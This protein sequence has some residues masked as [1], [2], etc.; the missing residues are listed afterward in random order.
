MMRSLRAVA[1]VLA[2]LAF[3]VSAAAQPVPQILEITL[4]TTVQPGQEF[5]FTVRATNRGE[6]AA[7]GSISVSFPD[8]D[9]V[10]V[11]DSS[12]LTSPGLIRQ[13]LHDRPAFIQFRTEPERALCVSAGGN[14][15]GGAVAARRRAFPDPSGC[16]T[17]QPCKLP[18]AGACHASDDRRLFH[19]PVLGTARPTGV[20]GANGRS[21]G[22]SASSAE[23]RTHQL[24]HRQAKRPATANN[25][26]HSADY[27]PSTRDGRSTADN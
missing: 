5:T 13:G 18:H 15:P 12:R 10:R 26:R 27:P 11:V 4:P 2:A 21:P 1:I 7:K 8:Q 3:P 25:W 16:R 19:I 20:P 23:P 14:V 6:V 9:V 24:V 22:E 17:G